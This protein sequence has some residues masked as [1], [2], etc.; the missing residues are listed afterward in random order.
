MRGADR[1]P[2]SDSTLP[3][4]MPRPAAAAKSRV[5]DKS[6]TKPLIPFSDVV[7]IV[8]LVVSMFALCLFVVWCERSAHVAEPK[9]FAGTG[10]IWSIDRVSKLKKCDTI[11]VDIDPS[12][13]GEMRINKDGPNCVNT[14]MIFRLPLDWE[15]TSEHPKQN[16][17][18]S[19]SSLTA[20]YEV[21]HV[22]A[23]SAR[24]HFWVPSLGVGYW[25]YW[26]QASFL[27]V[28]DNTT[29]PLAE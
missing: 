10:L 28:V 5:P 24:D 13:A 27:I 14:S 22:Y 18:E 9:S 4:I 20:K 2:F 6:P 11:T 15:I 8:A 19:M 21:P 17:Y 12:S 1:S 26:N 23:D 29:E 3:P 16:P 25:A 7:G